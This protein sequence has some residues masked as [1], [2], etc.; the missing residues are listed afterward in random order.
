MFL[1]LSV[2]KLERMFEDVTKKKSETRNESVRQNGPTKWN[3]TRNI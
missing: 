1:R 3:S 2:E